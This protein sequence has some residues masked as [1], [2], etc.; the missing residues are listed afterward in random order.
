MGAITPCSGCNSYYGDGGSRTLDVNQVTFGTNVLRKV[1][2][3]PRVSHIIRDLDAKLTGLSPRGW[4]TI[5]TK[6]TEETEGCSQS[7]VHDGLICD[8]RAALRR[9]SFTN[10]AP[11]S[12][13]GL[14]MNL[15]LY[16]GFVR[17]EAEVSDA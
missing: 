11:H 13:N 9:I 2:H 10:Y 4:A 1:K 7:D 17:D 6:F 3:W 12:L 8:D 15:I 5:N 14:E 16:N